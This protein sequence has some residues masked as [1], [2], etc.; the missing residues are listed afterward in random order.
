MA[1]ARVY[2]RH[3]F[4]TVVVA[5]A[6]LG[7][8]PPSGAFGSSRVT[9]FAPSDSSPRESVVDS[10]PLL[11][12]RTSSTVTPGLAGERDITD[13]VAC[14]LLRGPC[15]ENKTVTDDW[16]VPART[17]RRDHL[18]NQVAKWHSPYD[19]TRT[20]PAG[21]V[22]RDDRLEELFLAQFCSEKIDFENQGGTV[23]GGQEC[24]S[25]DASTAL[26]RKPDVVDAYCAASRATRAA[27]P[28]R[29]PSFWD[30]APPGLLDP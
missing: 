2:Q 18:Q 15:R 10:C 3:G 5:L 16:V 7:E 1:V 26:R 21:F 25:V 28:P 24:A 4:R 23:L 27:P 12:R 19:P 13:V 6:G 17:R 20:R 11:N 9:W 30:G 29:R 14:D 8:R 22:E